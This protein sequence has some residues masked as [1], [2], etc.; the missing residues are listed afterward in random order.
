MPRC[1]PRCPS[2]PLVVLMLALAVLLPT[3]LFAQMGMGG[4]GGAGPSP[5]LDRVDTLAFAKN[6]TLLAGAGENKIRVWTRE[7][8]KLVR[9]MTTEPWIQRI[10]AAPRGTIQ[11]VLCHDRVALWDIEAGVVFKT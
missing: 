9:T 7:P 10:E 8:C 5:P 4:M 6:G 3:C 1:L 2:V 11:A